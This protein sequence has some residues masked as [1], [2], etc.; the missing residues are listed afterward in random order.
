MKQKLGHHA[1]SRRA[2]GDALGHSRRL[3]LRG[4]RRGAVSEARARRAAHQG[5]E[6]QNLRRRDRIDCEAVENGQE[7][8]DYRADITLAAL[9]KAQASFQVPSQ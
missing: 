1:D 5:E 8:G 9:K 7:A 6:V 2:V 4:A 3:S